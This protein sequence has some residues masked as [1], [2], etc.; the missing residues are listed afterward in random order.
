[1]KNIPLSKFRTIWIP[2]IAFLIFTPFSAML[3][4][5][6]SNLFYREGHFITHPTLSFLFDYGIDLT[7]GIIGIALL[8]LVASFISKVYEKWRRP[9]LFLILT[10]AIGSGLFIHVM[11]KDHWGRPRPKQVIEFGG[12]QAFRA[13][14]Q[15]NFFNQP[16]PSKSFPCGHCSMGFYFFSV[17]LLGLYFQKRKVYYFGMFLAFILGILLGVTRMAQGGHFLSDVIVSGLIMW[18]VSLGLYYLMF[19]KEAA[20]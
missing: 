16:Q 11:L 2:L 14:Y 12:T 13:Y 6:F 10:L 18:F 17:A 19:D 1:M 4:L 7:W 9:A 8:G 15:P 3:D 20:K 5:Y